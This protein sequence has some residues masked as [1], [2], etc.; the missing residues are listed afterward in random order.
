MAFVLASSVAARPHEPKRPRE[1]KLLSWW[2]AVVS[3]VDAALEEW[4]ERCVYGNYC[5]AKCDGRANGLQPIDALDA[6]CMAHDIC[7]DAP[8]MK[9]YESK[10]ECDIDVGIPNC[11]CDRDLADAALAIYE[12]TKKCGDW[13]LACTEEYVAK[14]AW[15]VYKAQSEFRLAKCSRCNE[16]TTCTATIEVDLDFRGGDIGV[17]EHV[18]DDSVCCE[19]CFRMPECVVWT[20]FGGVCYLKD[21][22]YQA[23]AYPGA[24]S[25]H[26]F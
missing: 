14:R 20:T 18:E 13:S 5:G 21:A 24:L 8:E 9:R 22:S 12:S 3:N 4:N 19:A 2:E 6:A 23:M 25:G 15:A 11:K 16:P 17:I 26:W 7:L 10:K 1:A